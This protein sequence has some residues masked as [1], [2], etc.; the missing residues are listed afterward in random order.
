MLEE[1]RIITL[2][3]GILQSFFK[4]KKAAVN[5]QPLSVVFIRSVK[6]YLL[7]VFVMSLTKS[8]IFSSSAGFCLIAPFAALTSRSICWAG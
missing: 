6:I 4:L 5:I 8:L 7:I 3:A 1:R 2:F